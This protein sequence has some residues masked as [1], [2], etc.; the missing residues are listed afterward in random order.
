M[1]SNV[2]AEP[3]RPFHGAGVITCAYAASGFVTIRHKPIE[4]LMPA[5]EMSF[6]VDPPS[7][8]GAA[9]KGDAVDFDLTGKTYTI[10]PLN[11][12][13]CSGKRT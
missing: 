13:G 1:A 7:L 10:K 9:K 8:I 4:A 11:I 12:F 5:M 3:E 6:A 2:R